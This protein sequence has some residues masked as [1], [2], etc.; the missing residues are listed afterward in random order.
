MPG[1]AMKRHLVASV[2]G[3]DA[4]DRAEHD[5]GVLLS[6]DGRRAGVHHL[7]RPLEQLRDI[8]PHHG[9]RDHPEVRERRI[10]AADARQ[11]EKDVAEAITLGHLLHLRARVR[12]G[13]EAVARFLLAD[14]V[15]H[16][17]EEILLEDVRLEA[18]HQTCSK[19]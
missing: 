15:L 19:R 8:D 16:P 4:E 11:A 14:D 6:R 1:E 5:A 3:A 10:T 9:R 7:I 17:L 12:D 2:V 18:C 13:D